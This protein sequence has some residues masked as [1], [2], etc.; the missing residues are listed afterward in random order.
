ML[1]RLIKN[2]PFVQKAAR[3]LLTA[4]ADRGRDS[5]TLSGKVSRIF[6]ARNTSPPHPPSMASLP[7]ARSYET[8]TIPCVRVGSI[9][10]DHVQTCIMIYS[11]QVTDR[12]VLAAAGLTIRAR[13]TGSDA[14][15]RAALS[16][17][18]AT[19]PSVPSALRRLT[20]LQLCANAA[21]QVGK[22]ALAD[23]LFR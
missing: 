4:V 10:Y 13:R 12:L 5:A 22:P 8:P 23:G 16:F 19:V 21:L 20:L 3:K 6:H 11:N 9:K 14:T 18:A 1:F 15:T 7:I 2:R 17:S